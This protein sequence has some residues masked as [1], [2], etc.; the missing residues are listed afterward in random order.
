[1]NYERLLMR[2]RRRAFDYPASK[3][4]KFDRV[5]HKVKLKY[6]NSPSKREEIARQQQINSD[7][8]L[9]LWS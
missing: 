2:L 5:L 6:L 9:R 8:M 3:A 1:M 7:N 4:D